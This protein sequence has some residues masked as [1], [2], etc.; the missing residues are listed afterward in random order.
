[1]SAHDGA[2]DHRVFIVRIGRE[3]LKDPLP[4]SSFGPAAETPVHI[5][6]VTKALRQVTPGNAGTVAIQHRLHEQAVVGRCNTDPTLLP[7]QQVFD[8]VPLVIAKCVT[9]H[10]SAPQ[11]DRLRIGERTAPESAI[12]SPHPICSTGVAVQTHPQKAALI[13]DTP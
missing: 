7:R 13:D 10:R 5:V 8:P 11:A 3:M 2:V 9:A 1:M 12:F 4:D 6:P